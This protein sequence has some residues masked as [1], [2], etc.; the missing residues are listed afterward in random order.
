MLPGLKLEDIR[1]H[2]LVC[3]QI[4]ENES[5]SIRLIMMFEKSSLLIIVI[6]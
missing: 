1:E 5:G 3:S 6:S 2:M 4:K